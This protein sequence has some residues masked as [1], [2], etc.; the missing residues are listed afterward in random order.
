MLK[1]GLSVL[2]RTLLIGR[3]PAPEP[4]SRRPPGVSDRT[5]C[6][7]TNMLN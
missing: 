6:P 7:I 3:A 1:P 4:P 5:R 2:L